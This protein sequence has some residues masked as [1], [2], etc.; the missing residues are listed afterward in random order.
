MISNELSTEGGLVELAEEVVPSASAALG[1]RDVFNELGRSIV[2]S[3]NSSL[4]KIQTSKVIR[5][6]ER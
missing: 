6:E 1:L 4:Q 3:S 5:S 2:N